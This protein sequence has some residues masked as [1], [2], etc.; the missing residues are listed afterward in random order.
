M[1]LLRLKNFL[2]GASQKLSAFLQEKGEH[3]A[4]AEV[5]PYAFIHPG[6]S[7]AKADKKG[8]PFSF[9]TKVRTSVSFFIFRFTK[10]ISP[11]SKQLCLKRGLQCPTHLIID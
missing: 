5:F 10:N 6:W 3:L 2:L 8:P 11:L 4:E 1:I 9:I 7:S